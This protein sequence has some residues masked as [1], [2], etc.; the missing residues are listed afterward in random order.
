MA[1]NKKGQK[2]MEKSA[3]LEKANSYVPIKFTEIKITK[4]QRLV[5]E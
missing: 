1:K 3:E 2:D 4:A 5:K